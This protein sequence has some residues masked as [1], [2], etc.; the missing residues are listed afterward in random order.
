MKKNPDFLNLILITIMF[1]GLTSSCQKQKEA[2]PETATIKGITEMEITRQDFGQ[3]PDGQ[4]VEIYTL[5]NT[6]G[7]VARLMTYGAT[8]CFAY[9]TRS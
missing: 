1:L 8:L 6:G 9:C 7:L 3:L 2:E 5:T 4:A